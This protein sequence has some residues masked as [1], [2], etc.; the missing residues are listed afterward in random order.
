MCWKDTGV[1]IFLVRLHVLLFILN[2]GCQ[3]VHSYCFLIKVAPCSSTEVIFFYY[4]ESQF[5]S[6][7]YADSFTNTS[8][9]RETILA[10]AQ[11]I[12]SIRCNNF[13]DQFGIQMTHYELQP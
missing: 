6:R 7:T 13:A 9:R 2:I 1:E 4:N 11:T 3:L 12:Y 8:L 5:L 10:C